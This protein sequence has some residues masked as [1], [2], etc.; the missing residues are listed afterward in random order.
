MESFQL[1]CYATE[2]TECVGP[3]MVF[4]VEKPQM[5]QRVR[6]LTQQQ[7]KT[8]NTVSLKLQIALQD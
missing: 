4:T 2:C 7:T 5:N 8:L 3:A 6:T 1:L